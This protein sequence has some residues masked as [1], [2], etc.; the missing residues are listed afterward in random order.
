MRLENFLEELKRRKLHKVAISYVVVS[1]L[2]LQVGDILFPA[3]G[4]PDEWIKFLLFFLVLC[5]PGI[6]ILAWFYDFGPDGIRKIV[7]ITATDRSRKSERSRPLTSNL[8]IASVLLLL[9]LQYLYFNFRKEEP[10]YNTELTHD[11]RSTRIA[12]I[13]FED[14]SE[15]T[16]I[17]DFGRI[18]SDILTLGLVEFDEIEVVSPWT[19]Q[20]HKRSIDVLPDD[21]LNRI[22]FRELT[23]AEN[24]LGGSFEVTED[25]IML[26]INIKSASSGEIKFIFPPIYGSASDLG[27]TLTD[28]RRKILSYWVVGEEIEARLMGIPNYASYQLY[29]KMVEDP[30]MRSLD[31]VIKEDSMFFLS[32]IQALS[33]TRWFADSVKL[34]HFEFL[35]RY[36]DAM[37]RHEQL[38]YNFVRNLYQGNALTAFEAISVLRERFPYD[39]WINQEAADVA[40]DELANYE[41]SSSIYEDLPILDYEISR[42]IYGF[43]SRI[44]NQI[45]CYS[46]LGNEE[47]LADL[48]REVP[49]GKLTTSH[50]TLLAILSGNNNSYQFWLDHELN[51]SGDKASTL[52]RRFS[53]DYRSTFSTETMNASLIY[54][55]S[56]FLNS[57]KESNTNTATLSRILEVL[58]GREVSLE[59]PI[60]QETILY[61]YWTAVGMIK[62]GRREDVDAIIERIEGLVY[63]DMTVSKSYGAFPYYVI[64]CIYA[65]AG[66]RYRALRYLERAREAGLFIG[67]YNFQY[68]KHLRNLSDMRRFRFLNESI[69]PET[70]W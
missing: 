20:T 15:D 54:K 14:I 4:I 44:R 8:F 3:F 43:S 35:D 29:L 13:P 46:V 58:D 51:K 2:Q 41:L 24:I 37:T 22:P 27:S 28:L 53:Y 1:W 42:D 40:N 62:S 11:I 10:I 48:K 55:T 52:L 30:S 31:R 34:Q 67:H 57:T 59:L 39:H 60:E 25:R 65:Q 33:L 32:R 38:W 49:A 21:S 5:F 6:L 66:E 7:P 61:A 26:N 16:T 63:P 64:G 18:A 17:D 12:V 9:L 47:K 23:G 68:D 70:F 19:I 69:D 50:R 45:V 56:T 36:E